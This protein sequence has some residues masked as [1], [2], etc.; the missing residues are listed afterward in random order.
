M[1]SY[2]VARAGAPLGAPNG[3]RALTP[4]SAHPASAAKATVPV[5]KLTNPAFASLSPL[6]FSDY[7]EPGQTTSFTAAV[8]AVASGGFNVYDMKVTTSFPASDAR[9]TYFEEYFVEDS[10]VG[11]NDAGNWT[12][13]DPIVEGSG[14][15]W[16]QNQSARVSMVLTFQ[17]G[18]TRTETIVS[19]SSTA[20]GTN[21]LDP[22]AFGIGGSLDMSQVFVPNKV[23]FY[24]HPSSGVQYS[25]V[26]MYYVTPAT[27]YNYWFWAGSSQQTILGI[28]YYTEVADAGA[29]TYTAYTASFEKTIG[30]LTTTG[31]SF[32]ST[33]ATVYAGSKFDTLAESVLRQQVVYGLD[34]TTSGSTTYYVPTGTGAITTN[35]QTRVVNIAGLKDFYLQQLNSD[36]ATMTGSLASTLYIPTG[37][38]TAILAGDPSQ[39]VFT[40]DQQITPAAGTLPFAVSTSDKASLGDLG[41]VFASITEGAYAAPIANPPPAN[42]NIM[43]ANT[44]WNFSGQQVVGSSINP[45][46]LPALTTSGTVEVWLYINTMTDTMGIVHKGTN[47]NFSDEA[48]SLQGWYN[49]GR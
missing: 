13:N 47:P 3:P 5:N 17:D 15:A 8:V 30:T 12:I 41:T 9:K 34:S 6:T 46:S 32:T 38:A 42:T 36:Y 49:N 11:V 45:A 37:S 26:V 2:Y 16:T 14:S 31:G 44:E 18:S 25:S 33:L 27:S 21:F 29:N 4:F 23:T 10:G 19:Q 1:S 7:P 40:R 35:M 20:L 22:S 43:P 48:Y 39:G 28:R 24:A